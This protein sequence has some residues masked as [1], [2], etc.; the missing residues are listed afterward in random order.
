MLKNCWALAL[1]GVAILGV[2][3]QGHHSFAAA[4]LEQELIEIEGDITE[5]QFKNP[6]AWVYVT[7]QDASGRTRTYAAEWASTS[8]LDRAGISQHT[9]K[10]GDTV[11]IWAA[12]NRDPDDNRVHLKR[13]VRHSD[14]WKWG[15][16]RP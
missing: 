12:P 16:A 15:Q 2:P 3:V 10:P 7:G 4:Y 9:L 14:G 1:L 8:R 13:I 5:F 11:R 6:H